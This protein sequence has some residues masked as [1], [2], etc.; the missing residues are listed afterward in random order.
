MS[1]LTEILTDIRGRSAYYLANIANVVGPDSLDSD[2]AALLK[3]ARDALVEAVEY[4]GNDI[5]FDGLRDEMLDI[6]DG[7]PSVYTHTIWKTWVDLC[8]YNEDDE[9]EECWD[10]QGTLESVASWVAYRVCE[11]LGHALLEEIEEALED[12]KAEADDDE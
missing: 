6:M 8:L 2:G 1:N 9:I 12:D 4:A 10:G 11:R 7:V 5:D 3:G